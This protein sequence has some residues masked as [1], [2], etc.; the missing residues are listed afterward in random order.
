MKV[1]QGQIIA[2]GLSNRCPNCGE[3]TLFPAG[4]FRI[5]RCCPRCE[6]GFD[7]GEGF[8]LGP[9]VLNYTVTVFGFVVPLVVLGARQVLPLPLAIPLIAVG[10]LGLPLLL[11]RCSWSWWL[12]LYFFFLPQK[13]PA[14]CGPADEQRED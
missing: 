11:Y 2:R 1:T 10:C 5:N 7:R 6:T 12:M 4:S 14:N 3:R 13:L 8:F 9:W